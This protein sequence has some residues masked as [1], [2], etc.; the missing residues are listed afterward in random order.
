MEQKMMDCYKTLINDFCSFDV[1]WTGP[2]ATIFEKCQK[3]NSSNAKAE[4]TT[5]NFLTALEDELWFGTVAPDS[6][7]W[8]KDMPGLAS[9]VTG[10]P[11]NFDSLAK[12]YYTTLGNYLYDTYGDKERVKMAEFDPA[13]LLHALF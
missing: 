7:H 3:S 6:V 11:T 12:A 2:N 5:W 10:D 13:T 1:T 4:F 9:L 8:C